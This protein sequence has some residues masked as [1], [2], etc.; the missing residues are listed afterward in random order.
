MNWASEFRIWTI[1]S[2]VHDIPDAL[3][4]LLLT[5]SLFQQFMVQQYNQ[6]EY[7]ALLPY[8]LDLVTELGSNYSS[9][10]CLEI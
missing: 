4:T 2:E 3:L 6:K 7:K 1:G 8:R 10:L 9:T 5:D